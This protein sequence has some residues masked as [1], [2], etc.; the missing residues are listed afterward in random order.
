MRLNPRAA[1]LAGVILLLAGCSPTGPD[2]TPFAE[3]IKWLGVCLVLSS[4]IWAVGIVVF[5]QNRK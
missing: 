2:L 5:G 1:A 3:A 4:L